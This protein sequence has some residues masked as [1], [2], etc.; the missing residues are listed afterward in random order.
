MRT[1]Y[2]SDMVPQSRYWNRIY[3]SSRSNI[4]LQRSGACAVHCATT[5]TILCAISLWHIFTIVNC[6]VSF[7]RAYR[8]YLVCAM[9]LELL[10]TDDF[11]SSRTCTLVFCMLCMT[12]RLYIL[13]YSSAH[14]IQINLEALGLADKMA[15]YARSSLWHVFRLLYHVARACFYVLISQSASFCSPS[16]VFLL[17]SKLSH[18]TRVTQGSVLKP[19][20]L[21]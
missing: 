17:A 12:G 15:L 20:D 7:C 14:Q 21:C 9:S 18:Y 19:F 3:Y 4:A 8:L 11:V 16:T 5:S 10:R 2:K 1:Q 6:Q 13:E